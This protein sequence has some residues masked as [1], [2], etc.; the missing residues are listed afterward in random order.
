M[1]PKSIK[2]K[3]LILLTFVSTSFS[4]SNRYTKGAENGYMWQAMSEPNLMFS[5]SK[6]NY[7]SSILDRI[8]IT[9]EKYPE[10]APLSCR[11]DIKK[12]YNEGKSSKISLEDVVKAIDKFYSKRD[13]LI[14][15]IIFAYCY[16]IKKFAG[17]SYKEL[18]K[19][20]EDILKFCNG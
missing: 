3:L 9:G 10:I 4:Q 16:T 17:V 6:E 13:N 2:Y 14:I 20:R 8:R 18:I 7:L 5:A 15:P 12:I 11:E 19:Y 1:K